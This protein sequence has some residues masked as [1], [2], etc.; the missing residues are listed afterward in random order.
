MPVKQLKFSEDARRAL[1]A[2]VNKLAEGKPMT[3]D[4][5]DTMADGIANKRVSELTLAHVQSLVDDVV[6]VSDGR[7][8]E[9]PSR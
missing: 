5:I 3:L 9:V 6:T 1:E 2:G 8:I 4:R 7:A